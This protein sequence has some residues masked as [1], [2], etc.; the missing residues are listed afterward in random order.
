MA[1]IGTG[2]QGQAHGRAVAAT[3]TLT[4][5]RITGRDP[6]RAREVASEL[7]GQ[8]DLPV[9]AHDTVAGA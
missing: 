4:G 3:R 2:G 6:A 9:S 8:L 1:F 5:I 7:A